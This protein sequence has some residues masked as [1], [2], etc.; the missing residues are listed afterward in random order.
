MVICCV[1]IVHTAFFIG[2]PGW[3]SIVALELGAP[4]LQEQP[5]T[6]L[7]ECFYEDIQVVYVCVQKCMEGSELYFLQVSG[8]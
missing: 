8:K 1:P 7:P 2:S 6:R 4:T 5:S 3:V